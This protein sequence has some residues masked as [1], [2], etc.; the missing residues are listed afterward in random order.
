MS[1][2]EN[3]R[4]KIKESL[5]KQ[6][7]EIPEGIDLTVDENPAELPQPEEVSDFAPEKEA[8]V[9]EAAPAPEKEDIIAEIPEIKEDAPDASG[10]EDSPLEK[11]D[12]SAVSESADDIIPENAGRKRHSMFR[13]SKDYIES[14]EGETDA[15]EITTFADRYKHKKGGNDDSAFGR[16][17]SER[18]SK[19]SAAVT[20]E[21]TAREAAVL[22]FII[23]DTDSKKEAEAAGDSETKE[24][25]DPGRRQAIEEILQKSI[26]TEL[27]DNTS[28]ENE[29]DD[30]EE[31]KVADKNDILL[32]LATADSGELCPEQI[33]EIDREVADNMSNLR[34]SIQENEGEAEQTEEK[35]RFS[36]PFTEENLKNWRLRYGH[37]DAGLNRSACPECKDPKDIHNVKQVLS[38]ERKI[39]LVRTAAMALLAVA[40]GIMNTVATV[41]AS[42]CGGQFGVFGGSKLIYGVVMLVM[43]LLGAA[44]M[45]PELRS[46]VYALLKL[47]PKT[48]TMLTCTYIACLVQTVWSM[49][50]SH[51]A[52]YEYHILTAA[53]LAISIPVLIGKD[54]YFESYGMLLSQCEAGGNCGVLRDVENPA[55]VSE[56]LR[57]DASSGKSIRYPGQARFIS[58]MTE[59]CSDASSSS[60][61][62][63]RVDAI[64][65]IISVIIGILGAIGGHSLI[66]GVTALTA[67]LCI[68]TPIACIIA[69]GKKIRDINRYAGSGTHIASLGDAKK[70]VS[71]ENM[72]V[73]DDDIF[74][75]EIEDQIIISSVSVPQA[76]LIAAML[77]E[78]AG[79]VL[80]KIFYAQIETNR[81]KFVPITE[82]NCENRLG[83]S[84]WLSDCK[85]L[86]GNRTFMENHSIQ[87]PEAAFIDKHISKELYKLF[88]SINGSFVC[89]FALYYS[90]VESVKKDLQNLVRQGTNLIILATDP[91]LTDDAIEKM[92]SFPADSVRVLSA[93]KLEDFCETRKAAVQE[94]EAGFMFRPGFNG[95]SS[96]VGQAVKLN[97]SGRLLN[98]ITVCS[99]SVGIILTL[100]F[101]I[102]GSK[103]GLSAWFT[104]LMQILSCALAFILPSKLSIASVRNEKIRPVKVNR[105]VPHAVGGTADTEA[106]ASE[107]EVQNNQPEP[108]PAPVLITK[109]EMPY[110]D[111]SDYSR[112]GKY[113]ESADDDEDAEFK[114]LLDYIDKPEIVHVRI[115]KKTLSDRISEKFAGVLG[116]VKINKATESAKKEE[117]PVDYYNSGNISTGEE[118]DFVGK[119]SGE[120]MFSGLNEDNE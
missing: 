53:V 61:I 30:G 64:F 11:I 87:I 27:S 108:E 37:L 44:V 46:G 72:V 90:P 109:N 3:L 12:W 81:D 32:Q 97:E 59:K 77:A 68:S 73:N 57:D 47:K 40:T 116:R 7:D 24:F 41:S 62:R 112:N 25:T 54:Y 76:E 33:A 48:A 50:S 1:D 89:C 119:Y 28:G 95:F 93:S 84:G 49:F 65:G 6:N 66:F 19:F 99:A 55:T 71:S 114:A 21:P 8:E 16:Y 43:L 115:E 34:R 2:Y 23:N 113:G 60:E 74:T 5:A 105:Q 82:F 36:N 110:V 91:N 96:A 31:V 39:L 85:I 103:E 22:D 88:L 58:R 14:P 18:K 35:K 100:I 75:A 79:G 78:K 80:A 98:A 69:G 63:G 51:N 38:H 13:K 106:G 101:A 67:A 20:P 117:K 29:A 83:V 107:D 94:A 15:V 42:N 17:S 104:V 45:L 70:A 86:L 120:N 4:N 56:M 102:V 9:K 10:S 111:Y 118:Y 26:G 52:E 92:L